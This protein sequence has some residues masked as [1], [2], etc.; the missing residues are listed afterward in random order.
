MYNQ[1]W[2]VAILL[3]ILVFPHYFIVWHGD[4]M[5]I[6]R[7]VVSVSIQFHLGLWTLALLIADRVLS[8]QATQQSQKGQLL[9][10]KEG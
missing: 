3:I 5:G 1:A 2:W 4:I 9:M 8:L 10:R 6:Y 7:H